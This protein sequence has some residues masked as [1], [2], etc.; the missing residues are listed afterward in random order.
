MKKNTKKNKA[1]TQPLITHS[2]F[3]W[4]LNTLSAIKQQEQAAPRQI[5]TK[6]TAP[7][8]PT[9]LACVLLAYL[10]ISSAAT[11]ADSRSPSHHLEETFNPTGMTRE[12]LATFPLGRTW[13]TLHTNGHT[14]AWKTETTDTQTTHRSYF[15]DPVRCHDFEHISAERAASFTTGITIAH[16]DAVCAILTAIH[17][18][19][20]AENTTTGILALSNGQEIIITRSR[21]GRTYNFNTPTQNKKKHSR[22]AILPTDIFLSQ[23]PHNDPKRGWLSYF[24]LTKIPGLLSHDLSLHFFIRK[25]YC[26]CISVKHN[27]TADI[28]NVLKRYDHAPSA[29]SSRA[30]CPE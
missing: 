5:A 12:H 7:L 2:P 4:A 11:C 16:K 22:A 21:D 9:K 26:S 18:R 30:I 13:C 14:M 1:N 6:A 23:H 28:E 20:T 24:L 29:D 10:G 17:D 25:T 15:I 27:Y 3:L 19:L 8:A